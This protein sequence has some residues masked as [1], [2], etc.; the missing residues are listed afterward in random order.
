MRKCFVTIAALITA[1]GL[2]LTGCSNPSGGERDPFVPV[3]TITGLPSTATAGTPL[4]LAGTVEPSNATNQAIVWSVENPGTTGAAIN[5][6][7]LTATAAGTV[8]VL[9]TVVNGG[10]SGD[11]T[12][13][14]PITVSGGGGALTINGLPS[15]G[16]WAVYIFNSGADISTYDAISSAY[17]NG[18]YQALGASPGSDGAFALYAWSGGSQGGSFTGN[19]SFPALLLNGSGSITDAGNPMYA[20]A[21]VSFT[22]G[23]G[24][25][26]YGSFSAVV[27]GGSSGDTAV[28]DLSL[29]GKVTAPV[30]GATPQ[31]AGISGIQYAG[32]ISWRTENNESHYGAFAPNTVYKAVL[33]L[34]ANTG[35][36]FDGVAENSFSYSGATVTN[37]ANSGTATITFPATGE[38]D[39]EPVVVSAFSLTGKVTAPVRGATPNTTAINETQ[40]TGTI[41]W[42]T[43]NDMT[44]TG[45]FAASTVYKAVLTLTAKANYTF[46]GV[47]INSFTYTGATSVYNAA[48]SGTVTITFPAT[49]AAVVS[50]LS[51][52]SLVTAP[53]RDTLSNTTW[54]NETQYTG[55]IQWQTENGETH[56]SYFADATVYKAVVT[57]TAKT[58]YTFDGVAENS[59]TYTGATS[60]ANA[61][62]SG[63]VTITFP[64]TE[65]RVS[66]FSLDGKVTAPVNRA[67][68]LTTPV[69]TDQYTGSVAW[70]HED[71][72]VL[73]GNF[74]PFT[75]YKA[76]LTLTAKDGWT[77]DG[78]WMNSFTY[79]GAMVVNDTDSGTVTIIFPATLGDPNADIPPPIG[80]PSVKLYLNGGATAL[81]HSGTTAIDAGT[82]TY[83]V[84]ID[85]DHSSIVW[86]LN[87]TQLG[88]Y[89]GR[90]SITLSKRTTGTYLVTVEATP[91]GG[92][93]QSGAH[94]F[95][96]E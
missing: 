84:S 15:G 30:K 6:N 19:G 93:R 48:H 94:T 11:Y 18:S 74:E 44:H 4:T 50:A 71:G 20:Q 49:A 67:T 83:I 62:N 85:A 41:A 26:S 29:T 38:A 61:A 77:F 78:V 91:Q 27:Y 22:N 63:T 35:W 60:V 1:A 88:Q 55:S 80:N 58:N 24:A 47:S 79:T 96:V 43:S 76:V 56:Y 5:G 16:T 69:D 7:V 3:T 90:T 81:E 10:G 57:L 39:P 9:A 66:A 32:S 64:A 68:P 46:N 53:V 2:A 65:A 14:F 25:V 86:Y 75:V 28:T 37:A 51:L 72:T 73:A 21:T 13:N 52:D 92:Q 45:A 42:Q 31:T 59:F 23:A 34:Y 89:A 87:G 95:T 12:H 36:T 17:L 33:Y 70:E 40:Y 82:G 54:I 8:V